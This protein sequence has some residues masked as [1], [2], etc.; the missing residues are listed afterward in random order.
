M[1]MDNLLLSVIIAI[2][3]VALLLFIILKNRKDKKELEEN[4][5]QNYPHPRHRSDDVENAED[6]HI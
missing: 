5:K 2:L 1:L 4:I 3:L 6:S